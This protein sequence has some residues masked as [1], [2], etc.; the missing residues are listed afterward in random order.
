MMQKD[1]TLDIH[2]AVFP[3]G[4]ATAETL[5]KVQDASEN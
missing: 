3:I 1:T 2:P 5:L 4:G